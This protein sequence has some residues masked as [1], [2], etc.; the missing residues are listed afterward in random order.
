M[1]ITT[2]YHCALTNQ[3]KNEVNIKKTSIKYLAQNS[4]YKDDNKQEEENNYLI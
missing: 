1:F 2:S 3:L 4:S